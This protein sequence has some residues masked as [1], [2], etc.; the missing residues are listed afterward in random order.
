[1][2]NVQLVN[3]SST[4]GALYTAGGAR[5]FANS[6]LDLG[7]ST[8]SGNIA[9]LRAGSITIDSGATI[10][11][12]FGVNSGYAVSDTSL[13]GSGNL[14]LNSFNLVLNYDGTGWTSGSVLTLFSY[15]GTLTGTPTLAS[16]TLPSGYT[17]GSLNFGSGVV[18]LTVTA[19]P[20][21][22]T[23]FL[24]IASFGSLI[25]LKLRRKV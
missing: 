7:T 6:Q 11:D 12:T 18:S 24:V 1:A 5:V 17:A 25:F 22:S 9:S 4:V 23:A 10:V 15:T 2:G 20:E 19:V 14:S 13:G 3:P 16:I 8:T 21:P